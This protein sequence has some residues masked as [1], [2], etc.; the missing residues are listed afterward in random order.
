MAPSPE[1]I[2]LLAHLYIT[3]QWLRD[4]H[5]N[6]I[7]G[8]PEMGA[9]GKP[10]FPDHKVVAKGRLENARDAPG[11]ARSYICQVRRRS[12]AQLLHMNVHHVA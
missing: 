9:D 2:Q 3:R 10:C 1:D 12:R 8:Y 11:V 6:F 4:P 7:V 5:G